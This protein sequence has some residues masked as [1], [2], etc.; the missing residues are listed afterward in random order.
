MSPSI[1]ELERGREKVP[2]GKAFR[3]STRQNSNYKWQDNG[4]VGAFEVPS[5]PS[6]NLRGKLKPINVKSSEVE[7]FLEAQEAWRKHHLEKSFRECAES[8]PVVACCCGMIRMEEETMRRLVNHLNETWVIEV[9]KK[10]REE[11]F[12][13]DCF[14]YSWQNLAGSMNSNVFLIRFHHF[15]D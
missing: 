3:P 9:N 11:G 5:E 14:L 6:L 10:L 2:D 4:V 13:V 15:G 1:F 7:S 12:Q 8:V